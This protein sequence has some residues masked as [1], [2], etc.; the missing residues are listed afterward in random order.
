MVS[1]HFVAHGGLQPTGWV[2]GLVDE[3][4]ARLGLGAG[5][6]AQELEAC[7]VTTEKKL[8]RPGLC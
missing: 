7:G 2:A 4:R 8:S 1:E 3:L 5:S 6:V